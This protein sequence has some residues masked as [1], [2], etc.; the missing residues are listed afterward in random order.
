MPHPSYER[1]KEQLRSHTGFTNFGVSSSSIVGLMFRYM[2][3]ELA[4][5]EQE[6]ERLISQHT[7]E[8]AYGIY[9]DQFA[10]KYGVIRIPAAKAVDRT[11]ANEQIS[12]TGLPAAGY[13]IPVGTSITPIHDQSGIVYETISS[14]ALSPDAQDE[15][16]GFVNLE[17]KS[18]GPEFNVGSNTLQGISL[19]NIPY[20]T[21]LSVTNLF[22]IHNGRNMESDED[23]RFRIG[24]KMA[25]RVPGTR[26][27][28]L[29][30]LDSSPEVISHRIEERGNEILLLIQPRELQNIGPTAAALQAE[31]SQLVPMGTTVSIRL[32]VILVANVTVEIPRQEGGI[33]QGITDHIQNRIRRHIRSLTIEEPLRRDDVTNIAEEIALGSAHATRFDATVQNVSASRVDQRRVL[34]Y[35]DEIKAPEPFIIVEGQIQVNAS[36]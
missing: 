5:T 35:A 8:S 33:S 19:P 29:S 16:T 25:G 11:G 9:L 31:I 30:F 10:V 14:L 13:T 36:T 18:P 2:T 28:L 1:M 6:I 26:L 15:D 4:N 7:L 27:S 22:P 12:A 24:S 32:P 21:A 17:A 20:G 3:D 34:T 23:L